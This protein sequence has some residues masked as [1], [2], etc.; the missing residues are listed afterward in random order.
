MENLYPYDRMTAN[1]SGLAE[2]EIL[3]QIVKGYA[4]E[5]LV[6]FYRNGRK[7]HS[8]LNMLQCYAIR[9][10]INEGLLYSGTFYFKWK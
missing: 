4:K 10:A 6:D 1:S 2:Y 7:V 9:V 8:K 3:N 5:E